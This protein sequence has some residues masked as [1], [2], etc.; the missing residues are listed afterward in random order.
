MTYEPMQLPADFR[1]LLDP[2]SCRTLEL[3]WKDNKQRISCIPE[4]TYPLDVHDTKRFPEH[5]AINNVAGRSAILFHVG[6]TVSDTLGCPLL[7]KS[8][9]NCVLKDSAEAVNDF[10]EL[11]YTLLE[12]G[13]ETELTIYSTSKQEL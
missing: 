9:S 2:F 1:T 11:W 10:N 5:V 8:V 7:A 4:G 12:L 6:N 13:I 3:P